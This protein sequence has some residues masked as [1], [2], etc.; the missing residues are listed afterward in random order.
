MDYL[1]FSFSL[2]LVYIGLAQLLHEKKCEALR[3]G[4]PRAIPKL[5][6]VV[7]GSIRIAN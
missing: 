7:A 4:F 5:L 6:T 3:H 2:M 1:I